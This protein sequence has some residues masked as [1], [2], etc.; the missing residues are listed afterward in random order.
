MF[1][2]ERIINTFI[3]YVKI[4]SETGNEKE[5]YERII[6]DLKSIGAEVSVDDA[7]KTNNSNANNIYARIP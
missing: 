4:G 1:V 2:K 6:K 7:G 3:E 5:F